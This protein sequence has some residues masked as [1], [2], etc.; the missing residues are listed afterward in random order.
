VRSLRIGKLLVAIAIC[1]L[2]AL[3]GTAL[4]GESL[5]NWYDSLDKPWFLI[6][7]W[8]FGIVSPPQEPPCKRRS[9]W[10][11][12]NG[13]CPTLPKEA[14]LTFGSKVANSFTLSR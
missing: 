6:P 14:T 8:A 13:C 7:L 12:L 10:T 2:F 5:G 3:F 1:V 9:Q 4:F 11:R